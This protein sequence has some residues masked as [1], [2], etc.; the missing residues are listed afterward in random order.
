[1]IRQKPA[2]I[3]QGLINTIEIKAPTEMATGVMLATAV[4]ALQA[5]NPHLR[6]RDARKNH[7][8]RKNKKTPRR[9]EVIINRDVQSSKQLL[10][11]LNGAPVDGKAI[12][13]P[14]WKR[15]ALINATM[16][17]T[18]PLGG[19]DDIKMVQESMIKVLEHVNQGHNVDY[20]T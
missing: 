11:R 19:L 3:E 7:D 9:D 14:I 13:D 18:A 10:G 12:T 16:K 6:I 4:A 17:T 1:M 8:L 15:G 2:N 5:L 20:L